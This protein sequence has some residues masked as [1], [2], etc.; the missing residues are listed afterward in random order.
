[1]RS[2]KSRNPGSEGVMEPFL[3]TLAYVVDEPELCE[4][5]TPE[6]VLRRLAA[7]QKAYRSR[8]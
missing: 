3:A 2:T 7:H 4:H 1:M 8:G 5:I 6:E